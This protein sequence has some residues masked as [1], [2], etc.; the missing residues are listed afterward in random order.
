[1][2]IRIV[3]VD[4]PQNKRGEIALTYVY[5]ISREPGSELAVL[6]T[7]LYTHVLSSF[8]LAVPK[9][10]KRRPL[11]KARLS[12]KPVLRPLHL[13]YKGRSALFAEA[14]QQRD[15]FSILSPAFYRAGTRNNILGPNSKFPQKHL[16]DC[17]LYTS[18]CV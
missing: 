14:C 4:L 11:K 15:K 3:G 17:L 9:G 7:E 8:L 16:P 12:Q 13:F 1:M 10:K 5:G 18:R 2:A 6:I